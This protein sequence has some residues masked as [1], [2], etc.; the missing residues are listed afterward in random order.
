[1][2][3]IRRQTILSSISTYLGFLVGA[4]NT[5]L[6]VRAGSGSFT[7]SEYGLTRIFTDVGQ[8]MFAVG[9]FGVANLLYKFHPYY[10]DNLDRK[11]NDLLAWAMGAIVAGSVLVLLG[12]LVFE[13]FIVRKFS[14]RSDLFVVYY[15][16]VFPFGLG[17]LFFNVLE[18]YAWTVKHSVFSTFLREAAVRMYALVLIIPYYLKWIDFDTFIKL[19]SFQYIVTAIALWVYLSQR[20]FTH[21][22]FRISR[23]TRRFKK[24]ILSLSGLFYGSAII[25]IVA[26]AF[27][28]ILIAGLID[29]KTAGIYT[30]LLYV[31]NIIQVPLRSVQAVTI[32]HLSQAWKDKDIKRIS[33]IYQ[34]TSIN[35]LIFSS[36]LF[37][38]IWLCT[39]DAFTVLPI[40]QD[41]KQ[42]LNVI[43]LLGLARIIDG[44]TGVNGQIIGTSTY[45]RFDFGT[46]VIL[47][48]LRIP[49]NYVLIKKY[50]IT[51]SA[52]ADL[53]SL[54]V[55]NGIRIIFL[56]WKFNM[57]PFTYKT[58]L[59]LL[60]SAGAY[61]LV[62][63]SCYRLHGWVAIFSKTILFTGIYGGA[64]LASHL[65]PDAHQAWVGLREKAE[66]MMGKKR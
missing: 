1:M 66:K 44:G 15:H 45:F 9:S 51:G 5:Y 50:G 54:V 22:T 17:I 6:F 2:G 58:L 47:L 39:L 55:Y 4:L 38:L 8:I 40:Q 49:L 19:F 7:P 63:V 24:K 65:T 46:G 18:S 25:Q 29:L 11:D 32:P 42:G 16:W 52:V 3:Q 56:S 30:F 12:G 53:I 35:L 26:Q 10:K 20:Q 60:Y 57:Q 59:A 33:R 28:G 62:Y 34:R 21:L 36:F 64:V 31:A 43:L 41:Y 13:P 48:A 27:D 23:V 61:S 37:L 14:A